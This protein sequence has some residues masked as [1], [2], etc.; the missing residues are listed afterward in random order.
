[1]LNILIYIPLT[2]GVCWFWWKVGVWTV[3]NYRQLS[4]HAATVKGRIN[5]AKD[6][7]KGG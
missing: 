6:A 1:M 5:K 4:H 3:A 2:V 7:F